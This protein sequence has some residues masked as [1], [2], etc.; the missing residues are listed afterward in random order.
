MEKSQLVYFKLG[1]EEYA[2]DISFCPRD[3]TIP[4]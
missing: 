1:L 4:P 3:N 2:M